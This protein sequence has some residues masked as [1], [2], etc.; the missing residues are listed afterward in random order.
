[1]PVKCWE[2]PLVMV[3]PVLSEEE[4]LLAGSPTE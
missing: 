1:M 3:E 4:Q 2:V